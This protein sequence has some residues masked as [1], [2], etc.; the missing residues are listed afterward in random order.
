MGVL[1]S[2]MLTLI[3]YFFARP[4]IML[5]SSDEEVI[6]IG[7]EYLKLVSLFY[8]IYALQEVIQGLS[9]GT[10]NTILLMISTITAMWV[11]R[12]PVAKILSSFMGAKGV[13]LSIP[14]GWFV[15]MLFTNSYYVTG[16]WRT[17]FGDS[18]KK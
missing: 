15:A 16:K 10:G 12:V 7:V 13:W 17:K 2:L 5:F 11:V 1:I 18:A 14:T 3:M 8:V 6:A 9:V 4:I